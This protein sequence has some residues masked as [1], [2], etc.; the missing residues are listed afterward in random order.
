VSLKTIGACAVI[1]LAWAGTAGAGTIS[2]A[3]S[4]DNTIIQATDPNAQLS[5]AK[6][7]LYLGRTGQNGSLIHRDLIQFDIA[8]GR[9]ITDNHIIPTGATITSVTL[10]LYESKGQTSDEPLTLYPLLKP[11]GEGT[12]GTSL[13]NGTPD[14]NAT[15]GDAT[16]LYP[17]LSDVN[18]PS[19]SPQWTNPGGD[20]SATASASL[21]VPANS[22][23]SWLN[24][25][26]SNYP[27][28]LTDVRSWLNQPDTTNFGWIMLGNESVA[29]TLTVFDSREEASLQPSLAEP[30]LTVVYST[31]EPSAAILTMMFAAGLAAVA[32]RRRLMS[33]GVK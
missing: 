2:L 14:A 12:S 31:P 8:A 11:W 19:A 5:N 9:D 21:T 33:S 1:C 13:N 24:L 23:G 10:S 15:N 18:N 29:K 22:A 4:Q 3:P 26:S 6:G 30:E 25:S 20:Y 28:L 16:W 32:F 7:Y 27:Q 17:V